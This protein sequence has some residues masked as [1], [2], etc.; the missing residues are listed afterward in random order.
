MLVGERSGQSRRSSF[1]GQQ[2]RH[3]CTDCGRSYLHADPGSGSPHFRREIVGGGTIVSST[4]GPLKE[5]HIIPHGGTELPHELLDE[6]DPDQFPTL[7]ALVHANADTGTG[8]IYRT[9]V[10]EVA[11][12]SVRGT[13][14][15]GFHLSRILLDANRLKPEEQVLAHPYSGD[16]SLYSEYLVREAARLREE[17]LLPWLRAV[18]GILR[19]MHEG[20]VYHHHTYDL[21]PLSPRPWD[22]DPG[23]KRPAFQL[24]WRKSSWDTVFEIGDSPEVDEL[25]PLKE[26]EQARDRIREF[27]CDN[28]GIPGTIGAID[29]PLLLPVTPFRGT[30]RGEPSGAPHHVVYDLRKDFLVTE[31]QVRL[32]VRDSPWR[33][34]GVIT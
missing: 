25:A 11:S 32:W 14:V 8:A 33:L 26:I 2:G 30:R 29:H 21:I 3:P 1:L 15:A 6:I 17:M 7:A 34:A 19:Q 12:G 20:V 5:L 23:A 9:L 16:G 28:I 13:A 31:E 4:H 18:D 22:Q 27:L 24:A 10:E